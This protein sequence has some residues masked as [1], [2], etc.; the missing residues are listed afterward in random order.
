MGTTS[1]GD[2]TDPVSAH[3]P[4]SA[5]CRGHGFEGLGSHGAIPPRNHGV[6]EMGRPLRVSACA[7]DFPSEDMEP[8]GWH[9]QD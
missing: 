1:L 2:D 3:N 4:V 8:A 7:P 5:G 6:G 9:R